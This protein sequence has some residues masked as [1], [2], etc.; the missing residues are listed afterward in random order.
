MVSTRGGVCAGFQPSNSLL[1]VFLLCACCVEDKAGLHDTHR[2][3]ATNNCCLQQLRRIVYL[4][5][6]TAAQLSRNDVC[7]SI[8]LLRLLYNLKTTRQEKE[9]G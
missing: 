4:V 9:V 5:A 7:K 3:D 6:A 2:R 8:V 1:L